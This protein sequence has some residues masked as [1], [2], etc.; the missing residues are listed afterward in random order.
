MRCK[1]CGSDGGSRGNKHV[2]SRRY[3]CTRHDASGYA[4]PDIVVDIPD[5]SGYDSS[6]S[7]YDGGYSSCE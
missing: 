7:G 3:T 1:N 5:F 2:R 6:S 4:M